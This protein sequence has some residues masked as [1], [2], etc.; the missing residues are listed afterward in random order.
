MSTPM[1][2]PTQNASRAGGPRRGV[3]YLAT[4][5]RSFAPP[6]AALALIVVVWELVA[7]FGGLKSYV[8]PAP[9]DVV[10]KMFS[11]WTTFWSAMQPTLVA[12]LV[13]FAL[14][15]A[16][17]LPAA[18]LMVYSDW[19]RRS[20]YPL[21]V[22]A[23]LVPKVAIAPL[24]II[25]FGFGA[26]PKI[27]MVALISFFPLVVDALV[28]LT[29]VRPER[30][31]LVRSMGASRWQAFWKIRW[32]G[33][34][35]SI[36]SGAKVAITLAVV[37]AVVAE[38]VG[39]DRGLGVVLTEARGSLDSVTAFA[40]IAWLTILGSVLFMAVAALERVLTPGHRPGRTFE[41]AGRL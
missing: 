10:K 39:S 40:A 21:L 23:H 30:L 2:T 6:L 29:A 36:F 31:M 25:W 27:L 24:F 35:P 38:F 37:G 8:L 5:V 9:L 4:G 22:T 26:E 33:A 15:I 19:L 11:D 32:P 16:V 41:G 18:V 28:G 7:R 34:L 17:A 13:G 1:A 12:I 20:L 3:A 14:A